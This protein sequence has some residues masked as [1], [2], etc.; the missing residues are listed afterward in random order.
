MPELLIKEFSSVIGR[1]MFPVYA[2]MKDD[3][4]RLGQGFLLTLQYVNMITVPLGLGLALVAKPFVLVAFT[5]RWV[6]A[7]PVMAII[8]LYSLLRAMAFNAG[9]AYKAQGR[10]GLLTQIHLVQAVIS[11]PLL[12]WAAAVH[13]TLTAVAWSQ[14]AVSLLAA[15]I[16]LLIAGR[17]LNISLGAIWKALQGPL[18]AG[19]IMTV[20]V[21]GILQIGSSWSPLLQLIASTVMGGLTYMATLWLLHRSTLLEAGQTLR[22]S[23]SRR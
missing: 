3:G 13:G 16:K 11:I 1:V 15:L 5:D 10:P 22:A 21:L 14:L 19:A 6:E 7:I 4:P 18:T 2:K 20:A 9:D 17:I 23:L 8:A 12:W